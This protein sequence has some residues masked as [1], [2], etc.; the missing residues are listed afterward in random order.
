[1]NASSVSQSLGKR[2]ICAALSII[3]SFRSFRIAR[4]VL[5]FFLP[6]FLVTGLE[7]CSRGKGSPAGGSGASGS[8]IVWIRTAVPGPSSDAS[9]DLGDIFISVGL[10]SADN[11]YVLGL[12]LGP[13]VYNLGNNIVLQTNG[14]GKAAF[15]VKYRS[16]G[17]ALW[18]H[19][20]E[21]EGDVEFHALAVDARGNCY[22]AGYAAGIKTLA[23]GN[24]I[25]A[26]LDGLSS[27][28]ALIAKVDADG[29]AV[30]AKT[31][32]AS[33]STNAKDPNGSEFE[34]ISIDPYG[35]RLLLT[36]SVYGY[37][38]R[39]FVFGD[40]ASFHSS[41][42]GRQAVL[43]DYEIDGT[44][45][46]VRSFTDV[47]SPLAL[48][49]DGQGN[50]YVAGSV[51]G[52]NDIDFGD[53][54]QVSSSPGTKLPLLVKFDSSGKA[55][56]ARRPTAVSTG[57]YK[58]I[59]SQFH[60]LT[61]DATGNCYVAGELSESGNFDLGNGIPLKTPYDGSYPVLAEYD[62]GGSELWAATVDSMYVEF[63]TLSHDTEGNLIVGTD[64]IGDD[65]T[66][67]ADFGQ[68]IKIVQASTDEIQ[69]L[70]A[71][72]S[73]DGTPVGISRQPNDLKTGMALP[74]FWI[75]ALGPA[76]NG[77]VVM[78]GSIETFIGTKWKKQPFIMKM[79]SS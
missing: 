72:Y 56:W 77:A 70:V 11:S 73:R 24:G 68:G 15:L 50:I 21:S 66:L 58:E 18:V 76:A 2:G 45:A 63:Q 37:G 33:D 39:T 6:L 43:A 54:V 46:W 25:A 67:S 28:S 5:I 62:A 53:G 8:S 48:E 1:M 79:K 20:F 12:A 16:D 75:D 69:G 23:L 35:N 71:T 30:W 31:V 34:A 10:D 27:Q 65:V 19:S 38:S 64:L 42:T 41:E 9:V 36:G 32:E 40:G 17:T 26:D 47:A 49:Q 51:E 61:L 44:I 3:Q 78:V 55:V 60:A 14:K 57:G 74:V 7:S 29:K 13:I 52:G 4:K 59:S 22:L